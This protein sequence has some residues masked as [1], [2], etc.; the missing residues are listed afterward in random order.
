MRREI[1]RQILVNFRPVC[2]IVWFMTAPN[3]L[4]AKD[5]HTKQKQ[6]L[7]ERERRNLKA[8]ISKSL[9]LK[10]WFLTFDKEP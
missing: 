10:R 3:G 6:W 2:L 1:W 7:K 4:K 9:I 8:V 5:I